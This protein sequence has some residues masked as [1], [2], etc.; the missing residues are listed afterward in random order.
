M[1]TPPPVR[2]TWPFETASVIDAEAVISVERQGMR[3]MAFGRIWAGVVAGSVALS[4]SACSGSGLSASST[5]S[6][7]MN[8]SAVEQHEIVDQLA[9]Q[10][11]KP[12]YATPLGEPEV[13]YACSANPSLTLEEFFRRA[14]E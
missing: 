5:C 4:V 11:K 12:S 9:A 6:D 2:E 13:P 10:Y 3:D 1:Q 8:A 7:F 14:Q